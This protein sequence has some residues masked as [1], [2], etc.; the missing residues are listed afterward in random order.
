MDIFPTGELPPAGT[1]GNFLIWVNEAGDPPAIMRGPRWGH[2]VDQLSVPGELGVGLW[3]VE[4]SLEYEF[5]QRTGE[6]QDPFI[7]LRRTA[8]VPIPTGRQLQRWP[9]DKFKA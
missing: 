9:F 6:A 5:D 3:V 8:S 4:C 7:K 1:L 2:F